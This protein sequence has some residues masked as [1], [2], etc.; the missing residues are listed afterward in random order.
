[1]ERLFLANPYNKK[2]LELLRNFENENDINSKI[3]EK[4]D[5]ISKT[6]KESEYLEMQKNSNELE[7]YLFIEK[8]GKIID[9]CSII[10]EKDISVAKIMPAPTTFNKRRIIINLAIDY[11]IDTL[12]MQEVFIM[13][14][15][16]DKNLIRYLSNKGLEN[17]GEEEGSIVFL[18]E[19]EEKFKKDRMI[20]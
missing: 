13:A 18:T 1:M 9:Y 14:S 15:L 19:K 7:I 3:S 8:E 2:Y 12:N 20:I 5:N 11:A 6:I 10:G 17:I 16:K 4:L